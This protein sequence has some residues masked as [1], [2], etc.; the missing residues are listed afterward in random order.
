MGEKY[1]N[2]ISIDENTFMLISRGKSNGRDHVELKNLN[3][4]YNNFAFYRS[5]SEGGLWRMCL[6]KNNHY[7]KGENTDYITATFI[8]MELQMFINERYKHV[9]FNENIIDK[10][11]YE[12]DRYNNP[13]YERIRHLPYKIDGEI[14]REK[15]ENFAFEPLE[16]CRAADC[17]KN[18]DTVGD[19]KH[20]LSYKINIKE[21]DYYRNNLFL[22]LDKIKKFKKSGKE[23]TMSENIIR[24]Y[25][26]VSA[27]MNDI[28]VC[29]LDT[30]R[31][32]GSFD[33]KISDDISIDHKFYQIQIKNRIDKKEYY[34]YYSQYYFYNMLNPLYNGDYSIVLNVVPKGT[35]TD[36]YGLYNKIL[37][38]GVYI[39]KILEYEGQVNFSK[40]ERDK[41][42]IIGPKRERYNFIGD[43]MTNVWP[44]DII[45]NEEEYQCVNKNYPVLCHYPNRQK[46]WCV[47]NI[48]HSLSD[49]EKNNFKPEK[50]GF[51]DYTTNSMKAMLNKKDDYQWF[52]IDKDPLRKKPHKT[53]ESEY[54]LVP[55]GECLNGKCVISTLP[56][57]ITPYS[58]IYSE[59][60]KIGE[61]SFGEIYSGKYETQDGIIY[62]SAIK[63]IP[64][65]DINLKELE[66]LLRLSRLHA[67][68]AH[69]VCTYAGFIEEKTNDLFIIME[70]IVGGDLYEFATTINIEQLKDIFIQLVE[71]LIYIHSLGYAH[72]DLKLENIMY[73]PKSNDIKYIDFGMS[74]TEEINNCEPSYHLEEI[75]LKN[76]TIK[77]FQ[78]ADVW[79][80]GII[81]KELFLTV[82]RKSTEIIHNGD[83]SKEEK[84]NYPIFY[85]IIESLTNE[86]PN[87]RGSLEEAFVTLLF[88]NKKIYSHCSNL[89]PGATA[90]TRYSRNLCRRFSKELLNM[91]I[92]NS[93][94]WNGKSNNLKKTQSREVFRETQLKARFLNF[95]KKGSSN[96]VNDYDFS[97]WIF[98]ITHY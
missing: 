53:K 94:S 76:L 95:S 28:F 78:K 74:C 92:Y 12:Y 4:N 15:I 45:G 14:A 57:G 62:K 26:A 84:K 16:L 17:F 43:F 27:Y 83:F 23:R 77:D 71:G 39:Y 87:E 88:D 46:N 34:L 97:N 47:P 61:G 22:K 25:K 37:S 63:R 9:P 82:V 79:G 81:I 35:K 32:I 7:E 51:C 38:L 56:K 21:L 72:S 1:K 18:N 50:Y 55:K 11:E 93:Y 90:S 49:Y 80:L 96:Y 2:T 89:Y 52:T 60:D 19:F 24:I 85:N 86:N 69:V 54:Q 75:F 66:Y 59:K 10:C 20:T 64:K 3:R 31:F 65:E 13:I 91:G 48:N 67:C 36:E 6:F 68:N 29:D 33:F 8:S 70:H 98:D 44:L 30:K 5:N 42:S 58:I 73:I 40:K 41:R